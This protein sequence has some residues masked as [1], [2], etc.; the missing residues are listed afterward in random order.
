MTQL[1]LT[2]GF[3]FSLE[4]LHITALHTENVSRRFLQVHTEFPHIALVNSTRCVLAYLLCVVF[5]SP[6]VPVCTS[7]LQLGLLTVDSPHRR[8]RRE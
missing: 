3:E 6:A 8:R 2:Q 7:S 4:V 5:V 1:P